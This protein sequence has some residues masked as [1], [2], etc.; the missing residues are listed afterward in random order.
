MRWEPR[1][2]QGHDV[3]LRLWTP[4]EG[5]PYRA[6]RAIVYPFRRV[7]LTQDGPGKYEELSLRRRLA[8]IAARHVI[9]TELNYPESWRPFLRRAN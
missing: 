3:Q 7:P 9:E 5:Q 2:L 4:S 8:Q 6:G 1:D